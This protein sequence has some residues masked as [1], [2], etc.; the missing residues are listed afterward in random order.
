MC[1][2]CLSVVWKSPQCSKKFCIV[3]YILQY[4]HLHSHAHTLTFIY[5]FTLHIYLGLPMRVKQFDF[6]WLSFRN[7]FY[8]CSYRFFVFAP[9]SD[10]K[11]ICMWVRS[12]R[13]SSFVNQTFYV[14]N[15]S[16]NWLRFDTICNYVN[17][18]FGATSKIFRTV[19]N[20]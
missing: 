1:S 17:R 14:Q 2:L 11:F 15:L 5:I 6:I 8:W 7:W 16:W 12:D 9:R 19:S 20:E 13:F 10:L 18:S 3:Q 4:V